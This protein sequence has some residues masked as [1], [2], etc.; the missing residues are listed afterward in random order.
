MADDYPY[1][2]ANTIPHIHRYSGGDCHLKITSNKKIKRFDMIVSGSRST[3]AVLNEA[4]DAVR[5]TYPLSTDPNRTNLLAK[6]KE[7]L[8]NITV[9]KSDIR[10]G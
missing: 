3:Q 5:E 8:R 2:S 9:H 10:K 4:F 7:L 1:G 6:M